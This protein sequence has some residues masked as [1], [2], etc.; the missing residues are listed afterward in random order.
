MCKTLLHAYESTDFKGTFLMNEKI[1][2]MGKIKVTGATSFTDLKFYNGQQYS[3]Y[4]ETCLVRGLLNGDNE[5]LQCLTLAATYQMPSQLRLLFA[6]IIRENSPSNPSNLF[7]ILKDDLAYDYRH[8][9]DSTNGPF[10]QDDYNE[11]LWDI[12][13]ILMRQPPCNR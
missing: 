2:F 12:D 10:L 9:R 6:T 1:C 7:Q 11:A 3:N 4:K 13:D 5:W 8:Q